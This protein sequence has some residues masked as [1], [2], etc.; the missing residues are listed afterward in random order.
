MD[1]PA[2]QSDGNP[3]WA[4]A[5]GGSAGSVEALKQVAAGLPAHLSCSVLVA[6]HLPHSAPSVLADILDRS[7]P[8]TAVTARNGDQLRPGHIYVA[9]PN[10]HLLVAEGRLVLSG[11]PAEDGHRPAINALFRSVAVAFA[12]RAVGLLLSGVLD[13][14]VAGLAAIHDCGG[15]TMAQDP[16]EA[17][18]AGMPRRAVDAGVVDQ[19]VSAANV[20]RLLA[21]L[22]E[23]RV[24]TKHAVADP[25]VLLENRVAMDPGQVGAPD[26]REQNALRIALRSLRDRARLSRGLAANVG[27]GSLRNRYVETAVEAEGAAAVLAELITDGGS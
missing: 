15:S 14:G 7:G 6:I 10:R 22:V 2:A 16:D 21:D 3:G 24:E 9:V 26:V 11:G 12:D 20:G 4:V 17:I 25:H 13:D 27:P 8:L 1:S 19:R 23:R 5:V 18:F